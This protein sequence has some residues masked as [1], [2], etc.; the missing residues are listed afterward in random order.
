VLKSFEIGNKLA[1]GRRSG[2]PK[3]RKTVVFFCTKK[4]LAELFGVSTKTIGRWIDS[5]KINCDSGIW[6]F[7]DSL[8]A[9]K[10]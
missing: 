2:K 5:K 10:S 4:E 1:V 6:T 7:I 8:V 3:L 9:L